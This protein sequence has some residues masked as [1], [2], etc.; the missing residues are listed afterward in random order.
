MIVSDFSIYTN[1]FF[2]FKVQV[3]IVVF[4]DA[5]EL[6]LHRLNV[7]TTR[8]VDESKVYLNPPIDKL[9]GITIK[10]INYIGSV[11]F[12]VPRNFNI[13]TVQ[14]LPQ[15]GN[16]MMLSLLESKTDTFSTTNLNKYDLAIMLMFQSTFKPLYISPALYLQ[17]CDIMM[18]EMF[19]VQSTEV[20][21]TKTYLRGKTICALDGPLPALSLAPD[22][23]ICL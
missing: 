17:V 13:I 12:D 18:P 2:Y 16:D 6:L 21:Q 15:E 19:E 3:P 5:D 23:E 4:H 7:P 8:S 14:D 9:D 20:I 11:V 10:S 1:G 22:F